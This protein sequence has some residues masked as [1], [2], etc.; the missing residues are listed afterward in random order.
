MCLSGI[1]R[2]AGIV[3]E[4]WDRLRAKAEEAQNLKRL[5]EAEG[6]WKEA[7][8]EAERFDHTDRRT[9][10][11]LEGL[12]EVYWH[13]GR[14]AEATNCCR[15]LHA[16]YSE[17]FGEDQF[18]VGV[19]A[20]N[21]AM[22]LHVQE[23]Y[24]EAEEFYQQALSIKTKRLGNDHPDITKLLGN[25]ANLLKAC[26]RADEA[27]KLKS[28]EALITAKN[29]AKTRAD[30]EEPG[31]IERP[32]ATHDS[33]S[34]ANHSDAQNAPQHNQIEQQYGQQ[35]SSGNRSH[36]PVTTATADG[37]HSRQ[38]HINNT[39]EPLGL[40]VQ[41]W[42]NLRRLAEAADKERRHADCEAIWAAS[43]RYFEPFIND[44]PR[45]LA[46][47]LD[48][49]ADALCA[50]EK[51]EMAEQ[52]YRRAIDIKV[53]HL[54][55]QHI[56]VA[57]SLNNLARL[58]YQLNRF[59]EA[60]PL[61]KKCVE[62]YEKIFGTQHPDYAT[63]L[64]NLGTL[65]HIQVRFKDAEPLYRQALAI[66]QRTLGPDHPETKGLSRSLANLL[67]STGRAAEA[68]RIHGPGMPVITGT[69]RA[70]AIPEDQQL[71]QP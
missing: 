39:R 11:T 50:Q 54:G 33:Q 14:F 66:R 47:A 65:Y 55:P 19:I 4:A 43:V 30:H 10:L 8:Q 26:G 40:A 56:V 41:R 37:A 9:A 63:A 46:Y 20:T 31:T 59:H 27:D 69:W 22:L 5:Q 24:G 44:D 64:H 45:R 17:I 70:L 38:V 52:Y 29:W 3:S 32:T 16:I 48:S 13:L 68:D 35:R 71:Y 2:G 18:D 60:E 36:E 34:A 62:I 61:T 58:Y 1:E 25:Y 42:E 53:K 51:H 7:L 15:R 49:F 28:G 12:S 23:K 21:L 6:Y 57:R 67:R